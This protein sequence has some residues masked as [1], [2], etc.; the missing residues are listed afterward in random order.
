MK[1]IRIFIGSPGDV[2]EEREKAR[3]VV[4][5]LQRE[6]ED[7]MLLELVTWEDMALSAADSF[8]IGIE[9]KLRTQFPIDIA[10]FVFWWRLGSPLSEVILRHDGTPYRSGTE[11]EFDFM[12]ERVKENRRNQHE[13]P[14][15]LV[16]FRQDDKGFTDEFSRGG[17]EKWEEMVQQKKLLA[18]F[19]QKNF[20]DDQGRNTRSHYRFEQPVEFAEQLYMHLRALLDQL[21]LEESSVVWQEAPYRG[22]AVFDV[23]HAPIFRGREQ[24]I[25]DVQ[26][27]LRARA[28]EGCAFVCVVG[29]SGSGKSSL[30]RA[31]LAAKL[32]YRSFDEKVKEWRCALLYPGGKENLFAALVDCLVSAPETEDE[33][34]RLPDPLPALGVESR[35][36]K[37]QRYL[38]E[39]NAGAAGELLERVFEA[40]EANVKG[41]IS[42]L[43]VLDQMEE[44]W[45][46]KKISP[47]PFLQAVEI[48]AHLPGF[49]V[50]ATL[51][52]DFYPHAQESPAFLRLKGD[53]GH[54]DLTRPGE[55]ALR[56]IIAKP[57]RTAG[58]TFE[59]GPGGSLSER[60]LKDALHD[61]G[62]LP[63][64]QYA[65]GELYRRCLEKA[66]H[67][68]TQE[69]G[70]SLQRSS[71]HLVLTNA[72]Y[73]E[74]GGVEGAITRRATE[75]FAGLSA[76]TQAALPELLPLLV[77][78]EPGTGDEF[79]SVRLRS[80]LDD[81]TGADPNSPRAQLTEALVTARFLTTD[82]D[83]GIATVTLTHEALL[84]RWPV[85]SEWIQ[86]NRECLRI[87]SQ[88]AQ[89]HAH[90]KEKDCDPSLL[91][92]RGLALKE[93]RRLLEEA[94]HLLK[95]EEYEAL[96]DFIRR[97]IGADFER[98]LASGT[99][100]E[101]LSRDL[102]KH[103]P[104]I[105]DET[106]R[107]AL[108]A[109]SQELRR[110]AARL[111]RGPHAVDFQEPLI[112]LLMKDARDEVK[113]AAAQALV[114][115]E[116]DAPFD[117]I[118]QERTAPG[119]ARLPK[120]ARV[121]LARLV[122]VSDM[123]EKRPRFADWFARLP[124]REAA[125][126]QRFSHLL[127]L[128]SSMPVFLFVL[129][130]AILFAMAGAAGIKWLPS[131]FNYSAVQDGASAFRGI[132]A[133]TPAGFLIGGGTVLGL[134][135]Y[136]MVI[137]REYGRIS[138][139]RPF[140]ALL[141]GGIF[142]FV[143]G[144]FCVVMIALVFSPI[145]LRQIG[146]T[147]STDRLPMGLLFEGLFWTNRCGYVFPVTCVGLGV[148]M[149]MMTNSLRA[150]TVWPDFLD[151]QTA[152]TS[153]QQAIQVTRGI[154]KISLP[155]AWPILVMT[156]LFGMLG[157]AVLQGTDSKAWR[158][159]YDS[160]GEVF[161][162]G[163]DRGG[164]ETRLNRGKAREEE[165]T[166]QRAWKA[167]LEGR[168]LGVFGD[169]LSKVVGGY[170]AIVGMGLGIVMLRHG[171]K[172][173]PQRSQR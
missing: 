135:F 148:A 26:H 115:V 64:L 29:A 53:R 19:Y 91:L 45:S 13:G 59:R 126:V 100:P 173:D 50:V 167:S 40:E 24:E 77:S 107:Q 158:L 112:Q 3:R 16:Y 65:L 97:S 116:A 36:Q 122:S 147:D 88:V 119:A 47:E 48:L 151:R 150:S 44:L 157:L 90:W 68:D 61:P 79:L 23:H 39:G 137:G 60:I 76:E 87:R 55:T 170:F 34:S 152:V 7:R 168:A 81:L 32:M 31:G 63:L 130:P 92:P 146:W 82:H 57:A 164:N 105:W 141:Y 98:E 111:L 4:N 136:R 11:R 28:A 95:A 66:L 120:D 6:F 84:K 128:R 145:A 165:Q 124:R 25:Y 43:L 21:D 109:E 15:I 18:W 131:I 114:S 96:A 35:R 49:A 143:M 8:Q 118:L 104:E 70:A 108:A 46:D 52:S 155:Y 93:G 69:T 41:K 20:Q 86:H 27:Q 72:A 78:V 159:T 10:I 172:V 89:A 163:L 125:P 162:G 33:A 71:R 54:F 22:L 140:P 80:R 2:H 138:T 73:D 38:E 62:A 102:E 117:R 5:T 83:K 129:I 12:L 133:A 67:E 160:P 51:R 132:F 9:E 149:A 101:R 85:I 37:L 156:L 139:F 161:L 99:A 142:A 121:A 154:V 127:R 42:V 1:T 166:R 58:L 56:E 110:N 169:V 75:V 113:L 171:V 17:Q 123:E 106:L 14:D 94:S 153:P 103:H 30:A 74:I 144:V 134:T